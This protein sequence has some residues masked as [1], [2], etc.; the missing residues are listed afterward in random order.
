[1]DS[2]KHV[3]DALL[4]FYRGVSDGDVERF[5]EL[6]SSDAATIVIGTAPG[7]R[8]TDSAALRYGFEAEGLRID[9]GPEP[10]GYAEGGLGWAVDEPTFVFPGDAG[11][12]KTRVTAVLNHED[13]RWKLL[14][15]HVS[16]GVPDEEVVEL[17]ARWGT[18]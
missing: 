11:A 14:H 2:S 4:A 7:E 10:L 18:G 8:V 5:D 12:M 16:V 1:M 3:R 6:V 15:L 17:Q 9:A 13:D